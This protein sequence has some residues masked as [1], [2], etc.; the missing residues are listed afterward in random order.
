MMKR[1]IRSEEE[2]VKL[3]AG[4]LLDKF[5]LDWEDQTEAASMERWMSAHSEGRKCFADLSDPQRLLNKLRH[6]KR[7]SVKT[8]KAFQELMHRVAEPESPRPCSVPTP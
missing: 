3:M 2:A 7:C 1:T 4:M 5:I 6:Y 8:R